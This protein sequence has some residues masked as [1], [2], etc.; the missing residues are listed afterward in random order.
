MDQESHISYAVGLS[1]IFC[2]T[3]QRMRRAR[4]FF[5]SY[6]N[7]W[8]ASAGELREAGIDSETADMVITQRTGIDIG[9]EIENIYRENISVITDQDAQYPPLLKQI[10]NPPWIL[11]YRG[12]LPEKDTWCIGIVG[13]RKMTA[14]GKTVTPR[15][16]TELAEQGVTTVSGLA[17]GIDAC[18]HMHTLHAHG[19]TI[20][21][22]ASGID[23]HSVYPAAHRSLAEE[24]S[25]QGG[26]L[27]SE[28]PPDT[29][30]QTFFF[31]LR[32]RIISGLSRGV[33]VIE[34]GETSGALITAR[35][36]LEQ[37]RDVFAVPG[38]ITSYMSVGPNELLK[39]G[40]Y[41]VTCAQD[42]FDAFSFSNIRAQQSVSKHEH[43]DSVEREIYSVLSGNPM[44]IDE[45]RIACGLDTSTV[46]GT[47]LIMEMK[48]I[49]RNVGAQNYIRV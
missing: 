13:T 43:L 12:T 42:I 41:P 25:E 27:C 38:P 36:A 34:A 44:H 10:Y 39:K 5:S 35:Y 30:P 26:M 33:V 17:F 16:V 18:V 37:N 11:Y 21:V 19:K 32:N 23:A 48:K 14:Y 6:E 29:V 47:L 1:K 2:L 15:I 8:R 40:A 4:A 7:L 45:V 9:K 46:S 49:V 28:Y 3:P 22:L 20:A 31:P 24:I